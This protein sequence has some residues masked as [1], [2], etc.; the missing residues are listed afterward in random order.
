MDMLKGITWGQFSVFILAVTGIYYLYVVVCYY[1]DEVLGGFTRRKLRFVNSNKNPPSGAGDAS[2]GDSEPQAKANQ[3]ELFGNEDAARGG[4]ERFQLM[5]RAIGVIR[6]VITQ[7]IESKLDRENLLD[8]IREVLGDY[9]QLRK[10]EY[11][12]TINQFLI[13]VCSAELSMEVDGQELAG[14]WK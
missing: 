3:A 5:Q 10:T 2:E 8:H 13:R 1:K 14:L 9:R 7:G 11:A 4:D 12:E 6:R